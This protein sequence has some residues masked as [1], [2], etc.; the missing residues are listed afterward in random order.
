MSKRLNK[1]ILVAS[2]MMLLA[3]C[4]I[5]AKPSYDK[6]YLLSGE[7]VD[8][9]KVE[10]VT[11]NLRT[12]VYDK[13]YEN[14]SINSAVLD[15][16]LYTLAEQEIGNYQELKKSTKAEDVKLVTDIKGRMNE[17]LYAAITTGTYDSFRNQFNEQ[18][19]VATIQQNLT[20]SISTSTTSSDYTTDYVF[21]KDSIDHLYAGGADRDG[22][23]YTADTRVPNVGKYVLKCDY[24]RYMEDTYLP[25]VYRELLIEKYV[26]QEEADSFGKS[27]G[28]KIKYVAI[29][30][31][32]NHP[33]AASSLIKTYVKNYITANKTIDLTLLER[34][35]KGIDIE[36]YEDKDEIYALLK[37]AHI[38]DADAGYDYTLYGDVKTDYNKIT[39]DELTTNSTVENE[40]TNNGAYSKE[41]G[42][43]LKE[44]KI[45]KEEYSKDGWFAKSND[46]T[47]LPSS[48]SSRL[49]DIAVANN[50]HSNLKEAVADGANK[51]VKNVNGNYYLKPESPEHVADE[52]MD[53]VI[54]DKSSKTYY[55]VIV[56]EAVNIRKLTSSKDST[57]YTD[58]MY[59]EII[60]EMAEKYAA[61]ETYKTKALCHYLEEAN[62]QFHDSAVY[63][64]FKTT[65]PDVWDEDS[66]K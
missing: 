49:F 7:T 46:T 53:C 22:K 18:L 39:A 59:N 21:L 6:D 40:F 63:D 29:A 30:E 54:Y 32:D 11:N 31:N 58:D 48:I 37:D 52:N 55:I 43:K 61:R 51:Y 34:A 42:L 8:G 16:V 65:Y 25:E 13:L 62:I 60:D 44:N 10:D 4:D 57:Q 2:A 15:E 20:Y 33:E 28:R 64:Y 9:K 5:E 3:G 56:E 36:S 1:V 47:S 26:K 45:R 24:T 41:T 12:I 23:A 35:W 27:A 17:K 14:G 38:K 19:F 66:D 50:I